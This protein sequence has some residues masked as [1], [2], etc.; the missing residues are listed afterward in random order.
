MPPLA[1]SDIELFQQ[2]GYLLIP[3]VY[4]A[5]DLLAARNVFQKAFGEKKLHDSRYDS[6]TLLTDIYTHFPQLAP[7]V[8][9]E[10]YAAV[11]RDLLGPD[12]TLIPECAVHRERYIHW[13]KDTTVQEM[14]GLTS[15]NG[16]DADAIL[17]FATYFQE[18]AG[19]GGGLT[20]IPGTHLLPDPFLKL[21]S[22]RFLQRV[23]NKLLKIN[24]LSVFDA[25]ERHPEKTDI[26]MRMGDLLVFDVRIFHRATFRTHPAGPEK[27]AIFNTFIRLENA[28]LDYFRFMKK[29]PEPYYRYFREKPLPEY[30]AD[31]FK[32]LSMQLMY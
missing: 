10:K 26:P 9:N 17:Q 2:Q 29:R 1:K 7:L 6:D 8:F 5:D 3:G 14:A 25:L 24:R 22:P 16:A 13:H 20:V 32:A 23:W 28:G 4:R 30:L 12:A 31:H 18:N 21:Y 15:H 27:F 19:N 11:A